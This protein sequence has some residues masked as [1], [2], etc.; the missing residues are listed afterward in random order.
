MCDTL[1]IMQNVM[2]Q[3]LT[4]ESVICL[5]QQI[6]SR[7]RNV[8]NIESKW[9]TVG[10]IATYSTL[11]PIHTATNEPK[12]PSGDGNERKDIKPNSVSHG[13]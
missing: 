8:E 2:L 7:R 1:L 12:K 13:G 5:N 10:D 3:A 11:T 9:T 6:V 4:F